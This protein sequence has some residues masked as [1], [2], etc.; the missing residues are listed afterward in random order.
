VFWARFNAAA[1]HALVIAEYSD[2]DV[3]E[4]VTDDIDPHTIWAVQYSADAF[5]AAQSRTTTD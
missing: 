3:V 5:S 2:A 1:K 4:L